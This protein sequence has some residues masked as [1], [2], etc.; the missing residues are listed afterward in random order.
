MSKLYIPPF[1]NIAP[2][3]AEADSHPTA[4][5]LFTN[6]FMDLARL[7]IAFI[8]G[9]MKVPQESCEVPEVGVDKRLDKELCEY[10][11]GTKNMNKNHFFL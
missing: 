4:D 11:Q 9:H 6:S 10:L 5:S 7:I 3:R 2:K 1:C 8:Y